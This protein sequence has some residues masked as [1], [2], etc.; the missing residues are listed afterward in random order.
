M[1]AAAVEATIREYF[2]CLDDEDWAGMRELWTEDGE[3]RAV[4][5]RPRAG[6]EEVL[7]F[8]EKLFGP[9]RAHED[10]PTRIVVAGDFVTAEVTFY[11]TAAD[12]REVS[13]EAVDVF[14]LRDGRIARMSN[15]YDI[16][17]ARKALA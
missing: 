4:G 5:G 12:G 6:R 11:G 10:R 16:A 15:W 13:F 8:F 9:W 7:G 1:S 17:Y 14:D 3:L 2:R